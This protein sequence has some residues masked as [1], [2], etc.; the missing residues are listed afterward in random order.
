MVL[1]ISRILYSLHSFFAW[2]Y[3][4]ILWIRW[5]KRKRFMLSHGSNSQSVVADESRQWELE[6]FAS[7]RSTTKKQ[8]EREKWWLLLSSLLLSH[9]PGSQIWLPT[10]ELYH[11]QWRSLPSSLNMS[12]ASLLECVPWPIFSLISGESK[13]K[14]NHDTQPLPLSKVLSFSYPV[15]HLSY[16]S[17][18]HIGGSFSCS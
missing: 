8:R 1:P 13:T 7:I 16:S 14:I 12:K 18:C 6:S 10:R 9:S 2:C 3:D 11:P 17:C 5:L 15:G 4:K